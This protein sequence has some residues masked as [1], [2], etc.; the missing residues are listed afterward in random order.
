MLTIF[1]G[2]LSLPHL[3]LYMSPKK[4]EKSKVNKKIIKR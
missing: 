2:K 4:K 3:K 1:K